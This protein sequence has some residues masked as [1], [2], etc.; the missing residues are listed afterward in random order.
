[1]MTEKTAEHF[2]AHYRDIINGSKA[3]HEKLRG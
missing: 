3:K 1:M 2:A